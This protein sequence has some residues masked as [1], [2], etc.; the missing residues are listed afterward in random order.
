M[1]IGEGRVLQKGHVLAK[2]S[3]SEHSATEKI[4]RGWD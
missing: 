2:G 3:A 1:R 4:V